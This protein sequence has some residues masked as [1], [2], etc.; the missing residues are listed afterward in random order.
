MRSLR[1]ALDGHRNSLGLV[2]LIMAAAVIIDHAFP[3][4]GWGEA[5]FRGLT[6]EQQSLGGLAVLGF[7]AVSGYLVT[8]SAMNIDVV[9]FIWRRFLRIFPGFW[10]ALLAGAFI[11]GPALWLAYGRALGDYWGFGPDSPIAYLYR[12]FT[13]EIGQYQIRDLLVTT[14][15]F[16]QA[17]FGGPINGSIWTLKYEWLCYVMLA[18]LLAIGVIAKAKIVVPII[19]AILLALQALQSVEAGSAASIVPFFGDPWRLNFG[20]IFFI[21]ATIALYADKVPF[22]HRFG[23]VSSIACLVLLRFGGFNPL[24]YILFSY[25]LLYVAAALPRFFQR[26]G[27]R[28]DYSYGVYL[29]GWVGQQ[30]LAFLGVYRLGYVPYVLLSLLFAF[31][32]AIVSWHLVEKHAMKLKDWGPGRGVRHWVEAGRRRFARRPDTDP[33]PAQAPDPAAGKAASA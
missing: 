31:A 1:D 13:L 10:L 21:G 9:Q 12:N 11:V 2:R 3:L 17:G 26:V 20:L 28:N 22:D 30:V 18:G 8:R 5:P 33:D 15:P 29:Y 25:S 4:G 23:I 19:T 6:R 16:G 24:G 32:C 27:A 7:L 14:T